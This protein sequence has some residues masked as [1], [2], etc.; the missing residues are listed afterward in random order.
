MLGNLSKSCAVESG[1][2]RSWFNQDAGP[3]RGVGAG[4]GVGAAG[5]G[6]PKSR[7]KKL[8]VRCGVRSRDRLSANDAAC[9]RRILHPAAGVGFRF[10]IWS[11]AGFGHV[12]A[13]GHS[14]Q[15]CCWHSLRRHARRQALASL[16]STASIMAKDSA[17]WPARARRV[18]VRICLPPSREFAPGSRRDRRRDGTAVLR[19]PAP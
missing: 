18:A 4:G 10:Y 16:N 1:A 3:R 14:A 5:R 12:G 9:A 6:R 2:E 19:R 8:R 17:C 13:L 15:C 11:V 7:S